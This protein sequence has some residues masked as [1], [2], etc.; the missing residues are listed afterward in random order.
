ME[1]TGVTRADLLEV[2][3]V[4]ELYHVERKTVY[5]WIKAGRLKGRKAGRKWLFPPEAVADVLE[6]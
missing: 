4:M 2:A 5:R 1:N 6:G 3:D